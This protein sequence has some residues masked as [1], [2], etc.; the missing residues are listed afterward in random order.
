MAEEDGEINTTWLTLLV[1]DGVAHNVGKLARLVQVK[2]PYGLQIAGE[3]RGRMRQDDI[4]IYSTV[5]SDIVAHAEA[6]SIVVRSPE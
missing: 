1:M 4:F 6:P 2:L 5:R 3:D